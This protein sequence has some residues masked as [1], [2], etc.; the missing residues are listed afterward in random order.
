MGER[1][2][3]KVT[4]T[5]EDEG[6]VN[7]G[8]QGRMPRLCLVDLGG[9]N[10]QTPSLWLPGTPGTKFTKDRQEALTEHKGC[11]DIPDSAPLPLTKDTKSRSPGKKGGQTSSERFPQP[12][13]SD[14]PL[15]NS[16]FQGAARS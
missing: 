10:H 7:Q 6:T 14:Q 1:V 12:R 3:W 13:R 15:G 8:L 4:E 2:S 9:F 16:D 5:L 11:S